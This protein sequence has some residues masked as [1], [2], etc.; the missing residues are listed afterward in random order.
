MSVDSVFQ[1]NGKWPPQACE[2]MYNEEGI[3]G[4]MRGIIVSLGEFVVVLVT[5]LS[6]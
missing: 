6:V 2:N 5:D 1:R 4:R 3:S